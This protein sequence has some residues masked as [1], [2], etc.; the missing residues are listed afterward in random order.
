MDST[1][2]TSASPPAP[3]AK[4]NNPVTAQYPIVFATVSRRLARL[5]QRL[6][7]RL[8]HRTTRKQSVTDAGEEFFRHARAI[9]A[10]VQDAEQA[11]RRRDGVVRGL[12]RVALP[13]VDALPRRFLADFLLRYP[14]VQLEVEWSTRFVDLIGEG[15]DVALRAGETPLSEGLIARR[16]FSM[17]TRA[18]ASPAY[19]AHHE[20]PSGPQELAEHNCLLGFR[21]GV[22]PVTHWPLLDG[23]RIRVHGRLVTNDLHTLAEACRHGLGI[24]LLPSSFTDV[25]AAAGEIAPVLHSVVGGRAAVSVVY[26]EREFLPAAVRAFVDFLVSWASAEF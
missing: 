4:Q 17:E 11:L 9:L 13:P 10:A 3:S 12:L 19:L 1:S 18:W 22:R 6:G 7:A 20:G 21:E 25:A 2:S 8:L 16:L 15:Y 26:P 23:G 14:E 5:E 24:A